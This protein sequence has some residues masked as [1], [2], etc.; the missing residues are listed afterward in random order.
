MMS[1][2]RR[3]TAAIMLI[4]LVGCVGGESIAVQDEGNQDL[5][6]ETVSL[7]NGFNFVIDYM[8]I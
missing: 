4:V 3:I 2:F 1:Q 7:L 5:A 8:Y 6:T